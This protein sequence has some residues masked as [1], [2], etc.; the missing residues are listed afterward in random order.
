MSS[1]RIIHGP[2]AEESIST[3]KTFWAKIGSTIRS[4]RS[5]SMVCGLSM[6]F[7]FV[8]QRQFSLDRDDYL[9]VLFELS[10][11]CPLKFCG[12]RLWIWWSHLEDLREGR[13]WDSTS[14]LTARWARAPA[15]YSA[16][17]SPPVLSTSSKAL[18]LS[19]SQKEDLHEMRQS[20]AAMTS[21]MRWVFPQS[22]TECDCTDQHEQETSHI[23][24]TMTDKLK[25]WNRLRLQWSQCETECDCNDQHE[26][27]TRHNWKN[28]RICHGRKRMYLQSSWSI[29]ATKQAILIGRIL[30]IM[31]FRIKHCVTGWK[32]EDHSFWKH[33]DTV[34]TDSFSTWSQ[35]QTHWK[36]DHNIKCFD[37]SIKTS[38]TAYTQWRHPNDVFMISSR[39]AI[40]PRNN[41]AVQIMLSWSHR[42]IKYFR[43]SISEDA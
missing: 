22:E 13:S 10:L 17:S 8:L 14:S 31:P 42:G 21:V 5:E 2:I 33:S 39:H 36:S 20:A 41:Q 40:L 30:A 26:Q 25:H 35:H 18:K 9:I 11:D 19:K 23:T 16:A 38:N 1:L 7:D 32:Q 15:A 4:R 27:E 24:E 28:R 29:L 12:H 37:D 34:V 6:R 43:D 3:H